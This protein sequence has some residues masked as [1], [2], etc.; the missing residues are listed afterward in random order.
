MKLSTHNVEQMARGFFMYQLARKG[1]L[2][3]LTDSRF[4]K[5]DMLVVSPEGIH[6]GIDVKGQRTKNF[7]RFSEKNPNEGM[8]YAFVYVPE[9]GTP[10]VFIMDSNEAMKLWKEYYNRSIAR[11][12]EPKEGDIWGVN[13]KTPFPYEDNYEVLPK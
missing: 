5:Y 13:W 3:Q 2:I 12:Y 7:W 1:Y 8:Y 4:P 11:G 6:F 10:K 9:E